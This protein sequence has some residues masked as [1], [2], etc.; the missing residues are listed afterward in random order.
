MRG[1]LHGW[2]GRFLGQALGVALVAA[3]AM[4]LGAVRTLQ[5]AV[6]DRML[7]FAA[8]SPPPSLDGYP[9]VLVVGIDSRSLDAFP[10]AEIA[11]GR[12]LARMIRRLDEAGA[13][14]IAL[15]LDLS[16]GA[17]GRELP[18]AIAQSGR[19]VLGVRPVSG[20]PDPALAR[21]AAGVGMSLPRL[22]D[23]G[24]VRRGW[25]IHQG[26]LGVLPTLVEAALGAALGAQSDARDPAP[27][28]IDYRR[29]S[30]GIP[31]LSALDAI[32]GRFN[33]RD[34]AGRVVFVGETAP[35]RHDLWH[36]PLGPERPAVWI[37]AVNWR[38]RLAQ[39]ARASALRAASPGERLALLLLVSLL[40]AALTAARLR[41]RLLGWALLA[42][43]APTGAL[44]LLVSQ[45]LLLDPLLPLAVV[46]AHAGLGFPV[47][48]HRLGHRVRELSLA[49]LLPGSRLEAGVGHGDELHASLALL[50]EIA[51]ANGLVLLR[52]Q[53]G[54]LVRD[55]LIW[56][57]VGTSEVGDVDAATLVLADRS[58]RVFENA[59]P[60][61]PGSDGAA[62]YA[63][64][65]A[66]DRP[67]GVLVLEQ[68]VAH[69]LS[70]SAL[71]TITAV[72]TQ[73][74]LSVENLQRIASL[75]RT[76]RATL[77][78]LAA[79]I[80][81]RDGYT[82]THCRRI[83]LFAGSM[84]ERLGL[85]PD[86]A[87]AIELGALLH[88]VGKIGISDGILGKD[89]LLTQG[90]RD[91]VEEHPEIGDRIVAQIDGISPIT[92]GCVRH[93][94]ERWNGTGYPDGLA[95]EAIPLGARIVALVDVWDALSSTRPYKPAY[96]QS[97]VREIIEKESGERF[98]PALVQLFFEVLDEHAHDMLD[99]I[100]ADEA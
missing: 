74:A 49:K 94:H 60:G 88:D 9:D 38:T 95:G 26:E 87:E 90:E 58:L 13:R 31:V 20:L 77:T 48:R 5:H 85:P 15:D 100:A 61:R 11:D 22:D 3:L 24:R 39:R 56:M 54:E 64:L 93:H 92:V 81:A 46:A 91:D 68:A 47:V 12:T 28:E 36:T 99:L 51:H 2:V 44:V 1:D 4:Q 97:R 53:N 6:G 33:P 35:E 43:G 10:D 18:R 63:P 66:S 69:P 16:D 65:F 75:R 32:E 14:V 89:G 19:V 71:R 40:G 17:A 76:F 41:W 72:G 80:D 78:A 84:A 8:E 50:A 79:A 42:A 57:R 59:V 37:H 27:Y 98:E 25:R 70:D 96:T 73:L 30:P 67:I 62:I 82:E 86:Q 52:L 21:S 34:V 29:A 55:A 45:G 83:V 7:R 23:D